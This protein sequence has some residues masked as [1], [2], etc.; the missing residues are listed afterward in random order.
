MKNQWPLWLFMMGVA[1]IVLFA[2]NYQ[3]GK[4]VVPLS[5]IFP[6]EDFEKLPDIEYEFADDD[7]APAGGIPAESS[8]ESSQPPVTVV[9]GP[10]PAGTPAASPAVSVAPPE[11]QMAAPPQEPEAAPVAAEP[12]QGKYT[13]QVASYRD[14]ATA[15]QGLKKVQSSGHSNA[16]V[17]RADLGPKGTYYRIYV[18]SFATKGAADSYL[19]KVKRDFKDSFIIS[20]K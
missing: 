1:I 9:K 19:T 14:Q 2:F 16:Y 13:I 18:G 17:A 7:T 11:T 10:K 12:G 8:T 6:E 20:M 4:D 15:E 3:S 5:E